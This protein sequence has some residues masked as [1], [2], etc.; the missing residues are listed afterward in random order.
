MKNGIF[1]EIKETKSYLIDFIFKKNKTKQDK[2]KA[3]EQLKDL[4][5]M[6]RLIIIWIIPF[7]VPI[8]II[9]IK[10]KLFKLPSGFRNKRK[11]IIKKE[12]KNES[13]KK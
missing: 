3:K 10:L 8:N 4:F 5:R 11:K 9:G 6:V 13:D 7:G 1:I 12:N 2:I